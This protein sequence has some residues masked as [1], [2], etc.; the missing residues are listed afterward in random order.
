MQIEIETIQPDVAKHMLVSNTINRA[1][2]THTVSKYASAMERGEW[3][4]NGEAII[5]DNSGKLANGQHRLH[6]CVKS[7][8]P[9]K[10]LVV[11]GVQE[12]SFKTF[13]GGKNRKAADILSISGE[14]NTVALAS[15]ARYYLMTELAGRKKYELTSTQ[16]E[17][18]VK[19]FRPLAR[20]VGEYTGHKPR[21]MPAGF[22]GIVAQIERLHGA[23]ISQS[24]LEKTLSGLAL[25]K[26]DPEYVLRD[27]FLNTKYGVAVGSD[28][29]RAY[30]I[31][32]ANAKIQGRKIS[33]LRMTDEESFPVL[34]GIKAVT[35]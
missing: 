21:I 33:I 8:I 23:S 4:L 28:L 25:S 29:G 16:I 17:S 18:V 7:G 26:E 3:M 22:C 14:K 31:K 6:A 5:F 19:N 20:I 32:A 10:T 35:A 34:I 1:L 12:E 30:M 2:S 11:R 24:F 15:A 27:K 13:D 9:L